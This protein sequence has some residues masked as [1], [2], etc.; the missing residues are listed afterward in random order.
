MLGYRWV[1]C[2]NI[3]SKAT[4]KGLQRE[5]I[6]QIKSTLIKALPEPS[7]VKVKLHLSKL[8]KD[9]HPPTLVQ[10]HWTTIDSEVTPCPWG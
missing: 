7:K 5:S 8:S 2:T 9:P 3:N 4:I 10:G 6:N 1:L